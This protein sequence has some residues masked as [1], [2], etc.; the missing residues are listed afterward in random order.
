MRPCLVVF[1]LLLVTTSAFAA[2]PVKITVDADTAYALDG[3]TQI[4]KA[5]FG[6]TAYE[7]ATTPAQPDYQPI[8]REAG[9]GCLGFPGVVSWCAPGEMPADGV[10]GIERWYASDE[11]L[12]EITDAEPLNGS[13][14]MYGRILPACRKLGIEPMIYILGGPE[15]VMGEYGIPRDNALYGA[16]AANY[17][18]LLRR[19]DPELR[20]VHLLN[21]SNSSWFNAHKSGTDYAEMFRVVAAAIKEKNPGI[22]VGGPVTCWPP[23]WPPVQL[24]MPNWYT[25]DEWTMP[26]IAGAG[27]QLDFFDFHYYGLS[28]GVAAEEVQ[29]VANAIALQRGRR[30][31]V[32]ITECGSA[33]GEITAEEWADTGRHYMIK[34]LGMERLLMMYLD[35][36]ATVMTV[37]MHDLSAMAGSYLAEFLKGA[38]PYDQYPTY[39]LYP[40]WGQFRGTRLAARVEPERVRAMAALNG[41]EVVVMAFND[42]PVARDV[43]VELAAPGH[44]GAMLPTAARWRNLFLDHQANKLVRR[45]GGGP[46]FKMPPY[47]TYAV[48]FCMPDDWQIIRA[49][50]RHEFMGDAVMQ[51]FEAVG[52]GKEIAVTVPPDSLR[53]ARSASVRVG[54][55]GSKTGDQ[56]VLTVGV[57]G[58]R[59]LAGTYFQE[60]PLHALPAAGRNVLRFDL[61]GRHGTIGQRDGSGAENR[62]RV[63]S[64][65]LVLECR[66]SRASR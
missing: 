66:A 12:H 44:P 16:V 62:L 24:G 42:A 45:S 46:R 4:P 60:V 31:P 34:T 21:E 1:V 37:Q 50:E 17:V 13:R 9:I 54:L 15:W 26:L 61:Q 55:L 3:E 19:I 59:L 33:P 6:L 27:E 51:E 5:V 20:W 56:V 22:L 32:A 30:V 49:A 38:D 28:V 29:T 41:D 25:W 18:A 47:S 65:S 40:I 58:H 7:G 52:D 43:E 23:A 53:D 39:W 11:A 2:T 10:A 64:A 14:Y 57:E 63:S 35:R 8:L 36:P 48:R